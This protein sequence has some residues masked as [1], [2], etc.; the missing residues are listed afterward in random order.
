MT[1][2][3]GKWL[4]R[5]QYIL[6]NVEEAV[7]RITLNRPDKRNALSPAVLTELQAAMLEAD[8]RTDVNVVVL[9]G[10]GKDFCAGYDLAGTYAGRAAEDAAGDNPA[11]SYR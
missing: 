5:P 1:K 9:E 8:D 2:Y 11:I 4:Q 6:F 10:A 7:A 3:E